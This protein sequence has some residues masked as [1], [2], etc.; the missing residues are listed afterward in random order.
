MEYITIGR[1]KP[2][3][4]ITVIIAL[5]KVVGDIPILILI[6]LMMSLIIQMIQDTLVLVVQMGFSTL[7]AILM[8]VLLV[9]MVRVNMNAA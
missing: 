8:N 5:A 9:V 2:I 4:A 3:I 6:L 1:E 7:L